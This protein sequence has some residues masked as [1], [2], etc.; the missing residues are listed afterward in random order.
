[1]PEPIPGENSQPEGTGAGG[2]SGSQPPT[3]K[4]R[5]ERRRRS[6]WVGFNRFEA[7]ETENLGRAVTSPPAT[8]VPSVLSEQAQRSKINHKQP[9]PTTSKISNRNEKNL[10][11]AA[12]PNAAAGGNDTSTQQHR[13]HEN[14]ADAPENDANVPAGTGAN[15]DRPVVPRPIIRLVVRLVEFPQNIDWLELNQMGVSRCLEY[16][17]QCS[18]EYLASASP[19][20]FFR[21]CSSHLNPWSAAPCDD[22]VLALIKSPHTPTSW[23]AYVDPVCMFFP[24]V[25]SFPQS[26][27][28]RV[29]KSKL[30]VP[31]LCLPSHTT[32]D[33][34]PDP[35]VRRLNPKKP[36]PPPCHLCAMFPGER[37]VQSDAGLP[38]DL[39]G[40]SAGVLRTGNEQIDAGF[41]ELYFAKGGYSVV[42]CPIGIGGPGDTGEG[43]RVREGRLAW[44]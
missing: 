41:G 8:S 39:V 44:R 17:Y 14:N 16:L 37:S 2:H 30:F 32:P 40:T 15:E 11:A 21:L 33:M 10:L 42:V 4:R 9:T 43:R 35:F 38:E 13:D 6:S 3:K 22:L 34:D 1:M 19:D 18:P 28:P 5:E 20:T 24:T 26:D 23:L 36:K 29:E 31:A 27:E 12:P 25:G 7:A